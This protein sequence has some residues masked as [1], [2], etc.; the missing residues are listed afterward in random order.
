MPLSDPIS[1]CEARSVTRRLR[2]AILPRLALLAL[3]APV[4]GA[5]APTPE[6]GPEAEAVF[7]ARCGGQDPMTEVAASCRREMERLQAVLGYAAFLERAHGG[8]EAFPEM[9]GR[10]LAAAAAP[11]PVVAPR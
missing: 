8:P 1:R 3:A 6:Y 11:P 10:R 9:A 7:L 2:H 4:V 5:A